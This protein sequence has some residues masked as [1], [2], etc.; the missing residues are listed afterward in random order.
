MPHTWRQK[1][2]RKANRE[3]EL[4][5][6]RELREEAG[7][8]G[9]GLRNRQK[10]ENHQ[11]YRA[12]DP[13]ARI[14][15]NKR[16]DQDKRKDGNA[17]RYR[18]N[19]AEQVIQRQIAHAKGRRTFMAE[20]V[21][22]EMMEDLRRL[23]YAAPEPTNPDDPVAA[24][25]FKF[26]SHIAPCPKHCVPPTP[27]SQ[28]FKDDCRAKMMNRIH[29]AHVVLCGWCGEVGRRNFDSIKRFAEISDVKL[30]PSR[31]K[32]EKLAD[33]EPAPEPVDPQ[34]RERH[35]DKGYIKALVLGERFEVCESCFVKIEMNKAATVWQTAYDFGRLHPAIADLSFAEREF[36]A[37]PH[38]LNKIIRIRCDST[39]G[40]TFAS[41]GHTITFP[42]DSAKVFGN[43]AR[44]E[45]TQVPTIR[46]L[47]GLMKVHFIGSR[48][49]ATTVG[50]H[51]VMRN[52]LLGVNKAKIINAFAYLKRSS[53]LYRDAEVI[54][55]SESDLEASVKELLEH[56]DVTDGV[57][58][59]APVAARAVAAAA[60]E[61]ADVGERQEE[62]LIMEGAVGLQAVQ[63]ANPAA[64]LR[65]FADWVAQQEDPPINEFER[66]KE[67]YN[68]AFP[69]LFP[70]GAF[71]SNSFPVDKVAA[72]LLRYYDQR[73]EKDQT[74]VCMLESQRVRHK[75]SRNVARADAAK[76]EEIVQKMN[77]PGFKERLKEAVEAEEKFVATAEHKQLLNFLR[78]SVSRSMHKIAFSEGDR[79]PGLH[80]INSLI[81]C[82]G[83]PSYFLTVTP[84]VTDN[85]F[86]IRMCAHRYEDDDSVGDLAY[87]LRSRLVF[88]A[89]AS[90]AMFFEEF[91]R[92]VFEELFGIQL[93]VKTTGVENV[94][95]IF[96]VVKDYI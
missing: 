71:P 88:A 56:A 90:A 36:V 89:P 78:N 33:G 5:R 20:K 15:E 8:E 42:H 45:R 30:K 26:W 74:F 47:R 85:S 12:T 34:F 76:S 92:A 93:D 57:A 77:E 9:R 48:D 7:A 24:A 82:N 94:E 83:P 50:G 37:L 25:I 41:R 81:R 53:P 4:Q 18:P 80:I 19:V 67:L 16:R 14:A 70:T 91:R 2:A 46:N 52:Q 87:D 63:G 39:G 27:P 51:M 13:E 68:G 40:E 54:D 72:H 96:G 22:P 21:D 28:E 17:K 59:N 10:N 86:G 11:Q 43:F 38:P 65:A 58:K 55:F 35:E 44:Q 23:R 66:N 32:L 1:E 3:V 75:T 6:E 95:G 62:T 84:V 73:F 79:G 61:A 60:I 69:Y 64:D 29:R 31:D 49:Q